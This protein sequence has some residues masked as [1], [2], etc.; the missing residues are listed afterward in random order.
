MCERADPSPMDLSSCYSSDALPRRELGC[1]AM[2]QRLRPPSR[3]GLECHACM[4]RIDDVCTRSADL[5]HRCEV[6][7]DPF[8][9][10]DWSIFWSVLI[11]CWINAATPADS[12]RSAMME[13]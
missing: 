8:D 13:R 12:T 4:A 3:P 5:R 7:H 10:S 2:R 1:F 9:G 11:G 6:T